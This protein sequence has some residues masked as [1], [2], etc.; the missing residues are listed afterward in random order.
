MAKTF[1]EN[2]APKPQEWEYPRTRLWALPRE[3]YVW[4]ARKVKLATQVWRFEDS[5]ALRRFLH[6]VTKMYPQPVRFLRANDPLVLE[7]IKDDVWVDAEWTAWTHADKP[8]RWPFKCPVAI[9]RQRKV[10]IF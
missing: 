2:T 7:A 4:V 1:Q 8:L 5:K 3:R 6:R 10:M 9:A